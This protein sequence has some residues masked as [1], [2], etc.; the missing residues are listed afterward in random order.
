[1]SDPSQFYTG[2]VARLYAPLRGHVYD[3]P[4]PWARF[5]RE[6]GEPALELGCGDGDPLLALRSL[7]LDVDGLDS[8]ADMLERCREAADA[9]GVEVALHHQPMQAMDLPRSYRSIFL[10]GPTFNLLPDDDAALQALERI[11]HHLLP[12]GRALIPLFIPEPVAT[13]DRAPVREHITA[14]GAVMRVTTVGQDR[15]DERRVQA[16]VL[17]YEIESGG[18]DVESVERTWILHWYTIPGFRQLCRA[19]GLAVHE[20]RRPD[21]GDE[22]ATNATEFSFLVSTATE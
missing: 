9:G 4:A 3:D 12:S 19:A 17:R 13:D 14:A 10:A 22:N 11:R 15:D 20:V 7:G 16:T 2:L 8:S 18:P 21:D 6:F 1:M 5:I